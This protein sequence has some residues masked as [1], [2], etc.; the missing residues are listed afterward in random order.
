V[1]QNSTVWAVQVD[2]RVRAQNST[3][4]DLLA[5]VQQNSTVWAA[6]I[7]GR[8][9]AQNSTIGDLLASVQQNSTVWQ[10]QAKIQDS[11]GVS[12]SIVNSAPSTSLQGLV[13]REVVSGM[14]STTVT[15]TSTH[16]TALYS[17][18]SSVAGAQQKVTAYFIGSTHTNPSTF[19]FMSS[20]VIDRWGVNFGSGSSGV[21]GAN[22]AVGAPS[23]LFNTDAANALNCRIEG[24]S[25]VTATV[26]ARVSITWFSAV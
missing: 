1:Q 3:I 14:N 17:L 10:T 12:P 21:T 15:I 6:Q 18:I 23:W 2:G 24:G 8:V 4:G 22:L 16:S 13:V 5:S 9:R 11:S 25:S 20:N 7:D 26:V 19:V